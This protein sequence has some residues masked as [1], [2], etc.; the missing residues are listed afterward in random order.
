[1]SQSLGRGDA[2]VGGIADVQLAEPPL[3]EPEVRIFEAPVE[4]AAR[5]RPAVE[6]ERE[7]AQAR[8]RTSVSACRARSHPANACFH[9]CVRKSRW[10][11]WWRPRRTRPGIGPAPTPAHVGSNGGRS[12]QSTEGG[13]SGSPPRRL[14][15]NG[16]SAACA[17]GPGTRMMQC[18]ANRASSGAHSPKPASR[19]APASSDLDHM[20]VPVVESREPTHKPLRS[21]TDVGSWPLAGCPTKATGYRHSDRKG[22]MLGVQQ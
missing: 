14:A 12:G 4:V 19:R 11:Q 6:R 10:S 13:R 5:R 20:V 7:I 15:P 22:S 18:L 1:V 9:R 8:L 16:A 3:R 17:I 21:T 2:A